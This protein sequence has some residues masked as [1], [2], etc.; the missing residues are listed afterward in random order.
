MK[1]W[2]K[3]YPIGRFGKPDDVAHACLYLAS[4]ESSFVTGA[5]IPIDGGFT[6]H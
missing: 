2:M 1:E 5:V 6:A 4:E 3:D